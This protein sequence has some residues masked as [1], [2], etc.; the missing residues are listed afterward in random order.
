MAAASLYTLTD[1]LLELEQ[2][3]DDPDVSDEE[4]QGFIQQWLKAMERLDD[5]L[6]G[7][8]A[9]VRE[10][11]ARAK[12]L[13]NEA[14]YFKQKAQTAESKAEWLKSALLG[15]M[16]FKGYDK[17]PTKRFEIRV[18]ASGG[19]A[20]VLID[21]DILPDNLPAEYRRVTTE[22]NK[23]AIADALLEGKDVPGCQLGD[24]S[25]YVRIA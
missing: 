10:F 1:E 21:P 12:V 13:K 17:V 6:D 11:E 16:Q 14:D 2:V 23:Q 4:K 18:C 7:Y 20:P 19:K 22:F 24:R 3:L 9:L 15:F 5:K 25:K 8:C